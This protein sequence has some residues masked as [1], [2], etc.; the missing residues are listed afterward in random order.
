MAAFVNT[1]ILPLRRSLARS[2]PSARYLKIMSK[3]YEPTPEQIALSQE[4]KARANKAKLAAEKVAVLATAPGV[5]E[6][7][8]RIVDRKW[9]QLQPT[10][11]QESS[12]RR[13]KVMTWN[14]RLFCLPNECIHQS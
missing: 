8:G 6:D 5:E 11:N 2:L 9:I 13:V 12:V 1:T 14:V 3:R 10:D 7:K 4:R